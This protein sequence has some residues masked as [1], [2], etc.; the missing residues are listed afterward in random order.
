MKTK[1][2]VSTES[3]EIINRIKDTVTETKS[4]K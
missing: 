2:F 4:L 3:G 1:Y